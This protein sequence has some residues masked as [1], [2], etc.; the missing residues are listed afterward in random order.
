MDLAPPTAAPDDKK[1]DA[2]DSDDD[3][4][5]S[6]ALAAKTAA[7]QAIQAKPANP[8]GDIDDVLASPTEKPPTPTKA[9]DESPPGTP[10]KSDVPF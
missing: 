9:P 4:D 8:G 10:V 1:A 2:D 5:K 3:T 7:A 6:D